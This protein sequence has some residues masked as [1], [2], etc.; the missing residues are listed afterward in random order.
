M[1]VN[2]EQEFRRRV[3]KSLDTN[4]LVL[5]VPIPDE[6]KQAIK[7]LPQHADILSKLIKEKPFDTSGLKNGLYCGIELKNVKEGL[8]F[9]LKK[10]EKHQIKALVDCNKKGGQGWVLVRFKKGLTSGER[11]RLETKYFAIDTAFAIKID[12]VVK[13]IK[14]KIFS[15]PIE[16]LVKECIVLNYDPLLEKYDLDILWHKKIV[17]KKV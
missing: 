8:T 6:L 4:N 12:Q 3:E 5:H 17:K 11:K 14:A 2:N 10:L 1:S 16:V 9:N 7:V 15:I 13:W